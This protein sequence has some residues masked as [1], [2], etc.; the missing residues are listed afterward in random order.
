MA[1]DLSGMAG[2]LAALK[3]DAHHWLTSP[4]YAVLHL[5]LENAHA[6]VE[7]ALIEARR[8]VRMNEERDKPQGLWRGR[9]STIAHIYPSVLQTLAGRGYAGRL[10]R[11]FQG[12][13]AVLSRILHLNFAE[14]LFHA[15]RWIK[16]W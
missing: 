11:W 15:L 9:A 10:E 5:R 1:R 14:F 8:R 13:Y 7:A 16:A 3:A 2:E 6:A 12:Y 4:E